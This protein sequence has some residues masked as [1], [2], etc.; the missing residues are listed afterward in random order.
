MAFATLPMPPENMVC[1]DSLLLF[2][3]YLLCLFDRNR[4]ISYAE[5]FVFFYS[6]YLVFN[7]Q[8]FFSCMSFLEATK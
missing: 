7:T 6:Y 3:L 5:E 2:F 4:S 8:D 1:P